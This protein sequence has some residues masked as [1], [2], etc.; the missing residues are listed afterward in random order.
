[1]KLKKIKIIGI[2]PNKNI[3]IKNSFLYF[4]YYIK[5]NKR[6]NLKNFSLTNKTKHFLCLAYYLNFIDYIREDEN[7]V[8]II[9]KI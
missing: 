9:S 5:K 2:L 8:C 4:I 3:D 7:E 6:I 1:M